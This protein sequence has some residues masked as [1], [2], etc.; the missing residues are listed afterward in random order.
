VR[1]TTWRTPRWLGLPRPVL[2]QLRTEKVRDTCRIA[3]YPLPS[4]HCEYP[5]VFT[6][7]CSSCA[8]TFPAS[9]LELLPTAHCPRCDEPLMGPPRAEVSF[10]PEELTPADSTPIAYCSVCGCILSNLDHAAA[11]SAICRFPRC[12]HKRAAIAA[13]DLQ[14][15]TIENLRQKETEELGLVDE[16]LREIG[17]ESADYNI[18]IL[19][20][21]DRHLEKTSERRKRIFAERLTEIVAE[22]A[23]AS[24]Q[25]A[26]PPKEVENTSIDATFGVQACTTCQGYCCKSGGDRAYLTQQTIARVL[27]ASPQMSLEDVFRAY[28]DRVPRESYARSCIYHA[29]KGCNLPTDMRSD[30]CNAFFCSNVRRFSA[31]LGNEESRPTL[32]AALKGEKVVRLV[33]F[34]GPDMNYLYAK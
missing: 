15:K 25:P 33:V 30:T 14:K 9:L 31:S 26:S 12:H 10:V 34:N 2:V 11:A 23:L 20:A 21:F 3:E 28:L 29:E 22:V 18:A 5:T 16:K 1:L 4:I 19:P 13:M 17:L 6:V 32:A 24:E 8:A 7:S 27:A